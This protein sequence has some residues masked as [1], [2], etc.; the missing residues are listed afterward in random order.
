MA[1]ALGVAS[2]VIAVVDMSAKVVNWCVRYAQDVSHAKEDKT[3]LVEEV[4]RLN[5][6]SV[7]ARN[8]LDGPGGSKLKASHALLLATDKSRPQLQRIESQLAAGTGQGKGRLEALRWPFKSKDV[9]VAIRDIRQ[10]TEAIY[11]ALEIDQTLVFLL[12]LTMDLTN[13]NSASPPDLLDE[14]TRASDPTRVQRGS[15]FLPRPSSA[16][17]GDQFNSINFALAWRCVDSLLSIWPVELNHR[18]CKLNWWR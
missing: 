2:G 13:D 3:R 7:N 15:K 11:S 9:Q 4:T 14:Q 5:L 12:Q 8:L 6:A 10:C 18:I 1:E 17:A 16:Q